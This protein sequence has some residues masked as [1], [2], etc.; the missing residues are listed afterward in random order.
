M[1]GIEQERPKSSNEAPSTQSDVRGPKSEIQWLVDGGK[2]D[3]RRP[4]ALKLVARSCAHSTLLLGSD[5][6]QLHGVVVAKGKPQT[7]ANYAWVCATLLCPRL[8]RQ[9]GDRPLTVRGVGVELV[10]EAV[11]ST[12]KVCR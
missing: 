4:G 5:F 10:A 12:Q 7:N 8:S 1:T 9:R 6:N 3:K 11:V 2:Q